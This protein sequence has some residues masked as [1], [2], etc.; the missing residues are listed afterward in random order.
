[1]N[2]DY[3][4]PLSNA[5]K[6]MKKALFQPFDLGKWFTIGFTAFLAGLMDGGG[7]GGGNSSRYSS[8]YKSEDLFDFF[9]FPNVASEWLANHPVLATLIFIGV[10]LLV[11]LLIVFLWLSSRGK[12]MFLHNVVHN[13]AEVVAPWKEYSREGNSLFL[14]RLVFGLISLLVFAMTMINAFQFFR[15]AYFS[16]ETI[17]MLLDNIIGYIMFGLLMIIITAYISLFLDHFVV[18]IMYKHRISTTSAW[19]M[20]M[21]ILWPKIGYFLLYGIFVLILGIAVVISVVIF[22]FATLCIGFLLLII[23]FISAVVLL[24][25]SYTFRAFS[26]EFLG[27]FGGDYNLNPQVVEET[28]II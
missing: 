1:M 27:Q 21:S 26:I 12:F 9:N 8:R 28:Q 19:R 11:V 7:G 24:P 5:W 18:P 22:G 13:K 14:W 17:D 16:G 3:I 2:I 4:S 20:F 10:G 15:E 6:R 25:V 23:P